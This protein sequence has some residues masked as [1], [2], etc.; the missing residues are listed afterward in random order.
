MKWK[1]KL[2]GLK[3]FD[4]TKKESEVMKWMKNLISYYKNGEPGECPVC[5]SVSVKIWKLN[6]G[7]ESINSEDIPYFPRNQ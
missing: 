3:N 1:N 2:T 4:I 5:G 6:H 7:R